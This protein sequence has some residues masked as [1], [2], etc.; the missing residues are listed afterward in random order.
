MPFLWA[1][2]VILGAASGSTPIPLQAQ[3]PAPDSPAAAVDTAPTDEA[4]PSLSTRQDALALRYQR[5]ENT[6]QQLKE[7]LR[8]S[9][10]DRAELLDRALTQS[11]QTLIPDQ[12]TELT[13]LLEREQLGDAIEGQVAVIDQMKRILQLLQSEDRQ[14]ELEKEQQR[15]QALVRDVDKLISKQTD[16]RAITERKGASGESADQQQKVAEQTQQVLDKIKAQD[17][18]RSKSPSEG[19]APTQPGDAKDGSEST[20]PQGD[21]NSSGKPDPEKPSDPKP[22]SDKPQD[23]DK[24]G[25][26]PGDKPEKKPEGQP[27]GK[28]EPGSA[29]P[30]SSKPSSPKDGSKPSTPKS[31]SPDS[32]SPPQD[33]M[34]QDGS[35]QPGQ[36]SPDMPPGGEQSPSSPS[37]Q[38]SEEEQTPGRAELERA[39]QKMEDAI[40]ELQQKKDGAAESQD[41]ALVNLLKAKEKLEEILRQLRE[42]EQ[43]LLLAALESRFRDM[44]ARQIN[45]YNGTLGLAA[46]P[47]DQRTDRQRGRAI[48][49]ARAQDEVAL[50][51][52][53]SLTLLKEEGS[54]IAFPEAVVQIRDDMLT[55]ARRLER[56]DVGELTQGIQKDVIE[57]LE[58]ILDSLQKEIEKS[59]D[60]RQQQ[61]QQQ[62]QQPQDPALV[63]AL[64]EL[65]MLRSLQYRVNR[66]T[67]QLGRA[68]DGDQAHDPDIVQQ[69]R[70]LSVRQAKIQQTAHDLATGRNQ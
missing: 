17:A 28:N 2:V 51:A 24:P 53:K 56:A 34:P 18:E 35:P 68:V 32:Q 3:S 6:L 66:R 4:K 20:E 40:K 7:Y 29:K 30:G 21:K 70:E 59:K 61:G 63:D 65:K 62:Q 57:A 26:Q 43:E 12:L 48:E 64:S 8:K 19:G 46:V 33:G 5:F 58:E 23:G 41:Q 13:T 47:E 69:L 42:E 55:S 60:R 27:D 9:D 31:E 10:P 1:A 49:L 44:L 36:P 22:K 11:K 39:R 14:S 50:L 52:A 67:K 54:S 25:D 15:I 16:A 38:K 45:V 37:G